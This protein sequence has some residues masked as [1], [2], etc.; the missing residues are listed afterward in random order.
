MPVEAWLAITTLGSSGLMLPAAAVVSLQ[1]LA[2]GAG[3]IA[4]AWSACF[5]AAVGL[6][7][8][9]K[10]AFLGWGMG[11]RALD[12]TGISGHAAL[13]TAV[14]PVLGSLML[15]PPGGHPSVPGAIGGM[16][17]AL[18]VAAS[19][20]VLGLHSAVV[21]VAG[22]ALGAATSGAFLRMAGG[23]RG[24]VVRTWLLAAALVV[25]AACHDSLK[26][27]ADSH[28]IVV[29]MALYASGRDQP[30]TRAEWVRAAQR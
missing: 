21:V 7:L 5:A 1:L 10:L 14:L 19:R 24:M 23:R 6:V 18:A 27:R 17:L 12:F 8:A 28:D 9:S 29:R 16:A 4:L 25:I 2:A 22:I 13:A 20:W 3:R 30:F 11:I 15:A 26:H